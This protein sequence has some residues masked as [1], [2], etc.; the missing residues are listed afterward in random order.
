MLHGSEGGLCRDR[1]MACGQ[2]RR[3]QG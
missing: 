2:A 1:R 3:A